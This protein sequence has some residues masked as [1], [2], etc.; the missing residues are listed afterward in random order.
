MGEECVVYIFLELVKKSRIHKVE[1]LKRATQWME[2]EQRKAQSNM[3]YEGDKASD[4][5]IDWILCIGLCTSL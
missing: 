3:R 2:A 4:Y 5:K 1:K